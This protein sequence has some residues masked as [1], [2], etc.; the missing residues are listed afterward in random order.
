MNIPLAVG[1]PL[2]VITFVNE[3][4]VA[5]TPGGRFVGTPIPVT[6]VVV[7][8]IFVNGVLIHRVG[9]L[10]GAPAVLMLTEMLPV[11]FNDPQPPVNGM[12]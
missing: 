9:L 1:V 2:M 3:L 5:I 4:K 10:E 7:R 12:L 11:A 8:M 6:N